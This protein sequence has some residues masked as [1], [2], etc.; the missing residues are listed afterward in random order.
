MFRQLF[1]VGGG[2]G[3]TVKHRV[4]SN[5]AEA[6]LLAQGN[7]E[8]VKGF[9]ELGVHLIEAGLLLLLL[10]RCVINDVLIINLGITELSPVRLFQ[11]QPVAKC[12]EPKLQQ[13]VRLLLLR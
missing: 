12:L 6:L 10:R 1:L 3:N 5:I 7:A 11:R 13:K 2:D 8:F 9:Q 4:H